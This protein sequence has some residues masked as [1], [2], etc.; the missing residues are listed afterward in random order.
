MT[1]EQVREEIKK[2]CKELGLDETLALAIAKI[3]SNY[4]FDAIR[5]EPAFR[6][7]LNIEDFARRHMISQATEKAFQSMSYGPLQVM[8]LVMRECGFKGPL[9]SLIPKATDTINYAL[10]H[11]KKLCDRYENEDHIISAY[12][13]GSVRK[14]GNTFSNQKYVD[15]V[16]AELTKIRLSP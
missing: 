10:K 12:N 7:S 9:H 16:K 15:K 6:Y 14:I 4:I 5:Y 3:E 13:A 11:L 1:P 2:Q 8:G